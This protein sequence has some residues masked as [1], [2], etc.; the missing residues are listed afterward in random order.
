M[1]DQ[2]EIDYKAEEEKKEP[3]EGAGDEEVSFV[4]NMSRG[5]SLTS[6]RTG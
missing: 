2:D 3:T 5:G 4:P 6:M 1:A